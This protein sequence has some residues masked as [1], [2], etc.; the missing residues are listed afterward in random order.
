MDTIDVAHSLALAHAHLREMGYRPD[1]PVTVQMLKEVAV[2]I[3]RAADDDDEIPLEEHPDAPSGEES[4]PGPAD[5]VQPEQPSQRTAHEG[6]GL[7]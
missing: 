3:S 6:H 4:T 1:A 7:S 2:R 5:P